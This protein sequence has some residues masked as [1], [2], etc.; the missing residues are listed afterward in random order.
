MWCSSS[1]FH[2]GK[3]TEYRIDRTWSGTQ[4]HIDE[5][6]IIKKRYSDKDEFK[7]LDNVEESQWQ[8]FIDDLIPKGIV[9]LFFFDGEK[10]VG[11]AKEG[12]EDLAIKESF[13]SLL[14]IEIVEQL[15]A[16]L[17][18]NLMRNLTVDS[19]SLQLDFDKYKGGKR[20]AYCPHTATRRAIGTKTK[21]AGC[22]TYGCRSTR[23]QN[24]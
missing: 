1:F 20:R 21:H 9:K 8:S 5:Q 17:Q 6:L 24:I 22:N 4:S 3:E 7:P 16:D 11:I 13:K 12:R 14:G 15:R 23:G 19:K 10:I 2:S 18:V